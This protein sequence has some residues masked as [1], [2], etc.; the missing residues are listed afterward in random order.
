M[1]T[2]I[3]VGTFNRLYYINLIHESIIEITLI[4]WVRLVCR[5]FDENILMKGTVL[6][7]LRIQP[8][9]FEA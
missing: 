3:L 8:H 7:C 1:N 5:I 4:P 6:D 2:V 9:D